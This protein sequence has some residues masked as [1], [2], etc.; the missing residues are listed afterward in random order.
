MLTGDRVA[1]AE[2]VGA[3]LGLDAVF[4]QQNPADK[5]EH[6]R[7]ERLNAVTVMVGDGVN[8]APALAAATVGVAMGARGSTASSEAAD[9][10]LTTDRLD[11]LADAMAIARRSR[12]IAL[13]SATVGMGLSVIAM[14]FAAF[15]LLPPALGALL[16]EAID[17]AVILNSL[18]ALRG[19]DVGSPDLT[20]RTE[21]LIRRFAAEH[22]RMHDQLSVL[23]DTAEA[24]TGGNPTEALAMLRRADSFLQRTLLPHEHAEDH[25]LYPA[26]AAPLGSAQATATMSR[27]H[28]EIQRLARRLHSHLDVADAAGK[29]RSDQ[30]D[31]LLACLYGLYELLR[32]HFAQEEENYFVLVPAAVNGG[33]E[34]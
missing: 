34:T 4:A 14:V 25:D 20:D 12:H 33:L 29:L 28:A 18:R 7:A 23:R 21:K 1:P 5:I 8:D 10:V 27:M 32:L 15:G 30:C 16:Q 31:D 19:G 22:D 26:L 6:V 13:Q 2:E 24:L 17:V 3:V 9:I 11:R